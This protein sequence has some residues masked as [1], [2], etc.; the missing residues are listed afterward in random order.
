MSNKGRLTV[1]EP[2]WIDMAFLIIIGAG[3]VGLGIGTWYERKYKYNEI[4]E[5]LEEEQTI[6]EKR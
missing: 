6:K 3:F 5:E 2:F 1:R 4:T